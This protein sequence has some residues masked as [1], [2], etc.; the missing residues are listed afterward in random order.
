MAENKRESY[1]QLFEEI[2]RLDAAISIASFGKVFR[3]ILS[4]SFILKDLYTWKR[5]IIL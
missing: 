4:R 1:L 2:G 5:C 3:F